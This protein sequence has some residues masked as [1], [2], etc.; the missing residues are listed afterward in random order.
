M[1]GIGA[2]D[3]HIRGEALLDCGVAPDG[4]L[5]RLGLRD[6]AGVPT[7]LTLPADC[8][9]QLLMTLPRLAS[10]AL[11]RRHRDA[12]LRVVYPLGGWRV[13][14]TPDGARRILT[15]STED[16][17]AGSFVVPFGWLGEIAEAAECRPDLPL[18]N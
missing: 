18:P 17:F 12:S 15:L 13:E 4:S 3:V 14:A 11:R 9:A 10:E 1:D 16:G 2:G 8:L 5:V 7:H 6:E